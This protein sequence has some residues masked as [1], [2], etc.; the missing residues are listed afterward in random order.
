MSKPKRRET[1]ETHVT[2]IGENIKKKKGDKMENCRMDKEGGP[3]KR[4]RF[5]DRN[6]IKKVK[7]MEKIFLF[8]RR[9]TPKEEE[10]EEEEEK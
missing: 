6:T 5:A 4:N 10:E 2:K 1:D 7:P 3:G 8:V 9:M